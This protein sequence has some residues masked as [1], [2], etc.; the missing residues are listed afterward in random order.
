MIA[1]SMA[2]APLCGSVST[3]PEAVAARRWNNS[4]GAMRLGKIQVALDTDVER[5]Q[6]AARGWPC[7]EEL[8]ACY[9]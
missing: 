7:A 5:N 4:A 8:A 6:Q 2:T 9:S 1:E 3:G